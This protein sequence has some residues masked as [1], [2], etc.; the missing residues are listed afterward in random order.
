MPASA[1]EATTMPPAP[2]MGAFESVA[3]Y[4]L[5]VSLS[6]VSAMNERRIERGRR[7]RTG[8]ERVGGD[9][10]RGHRDHRGALIRERTGEREVV[11]GHL[12]G[13]AG[14]EGSAGGGGTAGGW[15]GG[16]RERK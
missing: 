8:L 9:T 15:R 11:C 3:P 1:P 2:A 12:I 14:Q 13:F 16:R 7:R 4:E 6:F 10:A 5:A